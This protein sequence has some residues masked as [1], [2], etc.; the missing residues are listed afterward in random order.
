MLVSSAITYSIWPQVKKGGKPH[1]LAGFRNQLQHNFNSFAALL[2]VTL[3]GGISVEFSH[4]SMAAAYGVVYVVFTWL[5]GKYYFGNKT[6]GLAMFSFVVEMFLGSGSD[7][8]G[9]PSLPANIA[10]LVAGV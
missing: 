7:D 1:N 9:P 2:E 5:M 10:F 6:V 8:A 4:L 3:L